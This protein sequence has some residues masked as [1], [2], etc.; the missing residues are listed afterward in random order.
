M[1]SGLHNQVPFGYGEE[2]IRTHSDSKADTYLAKQFHINSNQ[3]GK[4][5][6]CWMDKIQCTHLPPSS[7]FLY[8]LYVLLFCKA[9]QEINGLG[10]NALG[11][12]KAGQRE[13][14]WYLIARQKLHK[15][16]QPRLNSIRPNSLPFSVKLFCWQEDWLKK[17]E[18]AY[19]TD[20]I[21]S[22]EITVIRSKNVLLKGLRTPIW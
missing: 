9:S 5:G 19:C 12:L 17:G 18:S 21:H 13:E 16:P 7:W 1:P 3:Q 20:I 6:E 10:E 15:D 2:S 22:V 8:L 14:S 11:F 4:E